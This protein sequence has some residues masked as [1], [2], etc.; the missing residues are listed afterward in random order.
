[1]QRMRYGVAVAYYGQVEIEVRLKREGHGPEGKAMGVV[2]TRTVTLEEGHARDMAT[3]VVGDP[4]TEPVRA[5]VRAVLDENRRAELQEQWRA[6]TA[7][8]KMNAAQIEAALAAIEA[9]A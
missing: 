4:F 9:N 1:M 7:P 3:E 5:A 6:A 2:A 8:G